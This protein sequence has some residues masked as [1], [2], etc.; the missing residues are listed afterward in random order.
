[1]K[2]LHQQEFDFCTIKFILL[3]RKVR[4]LYACNAENDSEL[5]FE[6]NVIIT[7]GKNFD[8]ISQNKKHYK[9]TFLIL[10]LYSDAFPSKE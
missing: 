2:K 5:S 9:Y 1:M 4:T 6:P 8:V 3:Y 10:Q 7:N